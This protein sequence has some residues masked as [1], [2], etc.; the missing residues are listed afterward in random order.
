MDKYF[1]IKVLIGLC[2]GIVSAVGLLG[3]MYSFRRKRFYISLP[4]IIWGMLVNV[5]FVLL[6]VKNIYDDYVSDQIDLKNASSLYYYMNIICSLA[7]YVSQVIQTKAIMNFYNSVPLFETIRFLDITAKA[8]RSSGILVFVKVIL[9][10]IIIE[11][12][13]LVREMHTGPDF[14]IWQTFYA[15]YPTVLAN[16]LPN[17]I[18]SGFVICRETMIALGGHLRLIEKEANFYQDVRQMTLHKPFYRMQIFCDL[19]DK[20][21]VLAGHYTSICYYTTAFMQLGAMP[22]LFSL[23]SN[24][25]GI[26][27]GFFQQ[28]YAIA[29]T[30]INEES[31]NLFDAM[32][33]GVFLVISFS[34][35]AL[36]S[37]VANECIEKIRETSL[38]LKRIRLNNCDIRF[39]QSVDR[40]SLQIFVQQ[41]K[42]QPMGLLE[43]NISLMHD[44]LSAVTSFL[45]ILIQS[46]LTLRFSLK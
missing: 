8:V 11:I 12:N 15:L 38:I 4:L 9:F 6:Y 31:Y 22:I 44:V 32:T 24:L 39:R 40:F 18:F 43:I 17:C 1:L 45:L 14:N 10:P 19:S 34:E 5:T 26:T 3:T 28:Y 46:D 13:L 20:V 35:I 36:L 2:I 7:N 27:A 30:M 16:F 21:D 33:N 25:F 23:L 42:I 37:M 41:F 29:D